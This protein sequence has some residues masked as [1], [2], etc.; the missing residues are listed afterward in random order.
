M[1][2][3]F[4][5]K[6]EWANQALGLMS[7]ALLAF[8]VLSKQITQPS[9]I[10]QPLQFLTEV[11]LLNTF[12]IVLTYA[13]L[14]CVPEM[15]TWINERWGTTSDKFWLALFVVCF[16]FSNA[17]FFSVIG[18]QTYFPSLLWLLPFAMM[19]APLF[20]GL[21]QIKG[22]SFMYHSSSTAAAAQ[23]ARALDGLLFRVLF[24]VII[25][26]GVTRI[27]SDSPSSSFHTSASQFGTFLL[28]L[29]FA[30]IG[31]I[32]WNSVSV[33]GFRISGRPLFLIRLFIYPFYF[34]SPAAFFLA[35][36]LHGFEYF[37]F[38]RRMTSRTHVSTFQFILIN[39]VL[40]AAI[41]LIWLATLRLKPGY[42]L[43]AL[44]GF[45]TS[46]TYIHYGLDRFLY[47]MRHP[48]TRRLIGPL[49]VE[50]LN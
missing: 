23:N 2:G 32:M 30:I 15:K 38:T 45:L 27:I 8:G 7:L 9:L 40:T 11:V 14:A 41:A 49:L 22:L 34:F 44:S 24:A 37:L 1:T 10:N 36:V 31:K 48:I 46:L 50:D 18:L 33:D 17:F 21:W 13:M 25:M 4:R 5:P 35:S 12:H 16:L 26:I 28:W 43:I 3:I 47:R 19:I 6:D 39:A 29:S 42:G 20:H